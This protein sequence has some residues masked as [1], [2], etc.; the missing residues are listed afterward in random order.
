MAAL[1]L[2]V[3]TVLFVLGAIGA[4]PWVFIPLIVGG[5]VAYVVDRE[6]RRRQALAARADW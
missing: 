5:A 1:T 6:R 3:P 4:Y 2:G